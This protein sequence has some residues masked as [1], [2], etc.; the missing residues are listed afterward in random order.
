MSGFD[1]CDCGYRPSGA[2]CVCGFRGAFI[3]SDEA[4][5]LARPVDPRDGNEWTTVQTSGR[6][7]IDV[8][9]RMPRPPGFEPGGA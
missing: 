3:R 6:V 9:I 7:A 5:V 8:T 4:T 1:Q 2:P